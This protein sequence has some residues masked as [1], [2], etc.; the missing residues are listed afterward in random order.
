MNMP[1]L[2][3]VNP[4]HLLAPAAPSDLRSKAIGGSFASRL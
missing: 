4:T 2:M 1:M 3:A